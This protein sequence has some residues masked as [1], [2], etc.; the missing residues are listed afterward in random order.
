MPVDAKTLWSMLRDNSGNHIIKPVAILPETHRFRSIPDLQYSSASNTLMQNM[1]ET[2]LSNDFDKVKTFKLDPRKGIIPGQDIQPPPAM[3]FTRYP[4]PYGYKQNQ[5]VKFVH[6]NGIMQSVNISLAPKNVVHV[7]P[8][9]ARTVP[10]S[11]PVTLEPEESLETRVREC[12]A[13]LRIALLER[14]VMSRR[15]QMALAQPSNE[16]VLKRCWAYLGYMFRSGPFKDVLI[17]FGVD[18]RSDPKYRIYQSV[19]IQIPDS[20]RDRNK[21]FGEEEDVDRE[22]GSA[23]SYIFDGSMVNVEGRVW[24]VC[25]VTDPQLKSYLDRATISEEFD[26]RKFCH[27]HHHVLL[28]SNSLQ[29][30]DGLKTVH[31]LYTALL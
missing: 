5:A 13:R 26:V 11:S 9:D 25:D 30:L 23:K 18:P 1:R 22:P 7:I 21:W 16:D 2:L 31:G 29:H 3:Q 24:Q 4:I 12:I 28:M 20:S 19:S 27:L 14:P 17:A 8:F 15:V 10:S 6:E